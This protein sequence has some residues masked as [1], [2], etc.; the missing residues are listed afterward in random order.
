MQWTVDVNCFESKSRNCP[1]HRWALSGKAT[2]TIVGGQ[3]RWG[4]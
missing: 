3:V 2:T 1:F 4:G